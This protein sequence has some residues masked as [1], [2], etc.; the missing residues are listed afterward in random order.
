M[1]IKRTSLAVVLMFA[2]TCWRALPMGRCDQ[3]GGLAATAQPRHRL[4]CIV[5]T[6]NGPEDGGDFGP[7]TPG[8]R[9]SGLQEAFDRAHEETKDIY[10]AGG[11]FN[12]TTRKSIAYHLQD[13][14]RVPW[15]HNF[16]LDGGEYFLIYEPDRGD[17]V[18][19]D[20][21][22]NC[23]LKFGLVVAA[24]SNGAVVRMAPSSKGPDGFSCIVASA[25]EFNGLVGA[26]DVWGRSS[27]QKSTGL[28]LDAQK[29]TISGNRISIIEINACQRGIYLMQGCGNNTVEAQWIHLTNLALQVGDAERPNVSGNR[30]IAGISGDVPKTTGAQIFGHHNT[31]LLDVFSADP[32]RALVLEGPA[33]DNLIL[34]SNLAS[35]ITNRAAQPST[36][37]IGSGAAA[38]F[39]VET[40]AFPRSAAEVANVHPCPVEVRIVSPGKVFEWT[41]TDDG[42]RSRT[43]KG[44]LAAGQAFTLNPG[45]RVR[46]TYE[47]APAWLWKGLR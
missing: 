6:P 37:L 43:F 21:Q 3:P 8:T 23:R 4:N 32:S 18:I 15:M 14:L 2:L 22:M 13:T 45:D 34:S 10:I 24:K 20:S 46:F 42:G 36:R 44:G 41:E 9:T 30:L 33:R 1:Q 11:G 26:G 12:D 28:I 19:I 25:F 39:G 7:K 29:G 16:M 31:F 5:V 38:G 35:G 27:E 17:A 47:E 40:P